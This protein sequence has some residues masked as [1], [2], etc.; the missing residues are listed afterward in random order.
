MV[1]EEGIQSEP[2]RLPCLGYT[3]QC[4]SPETPQPN[5]MHKV[6]ILGNRALFLPHT[7][8]EHDKLVKGKEEEDTREDVEQHIV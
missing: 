1:V 5:S 4:N 2:D 6:V 3:S 7:L 8:S